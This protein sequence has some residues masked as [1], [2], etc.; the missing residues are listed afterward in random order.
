MRGDY[1]EP[2]KSAIESPTPTLG[3]AGLRRQ[4]ISSDR[5]QSATVKERYSF[6]KEE[7]MMFTSFYSYTEITSWPTSGNSAELSHL[8]LV[9]LCSSLK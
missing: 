9:K 5:A 4:T 7:N 8:G 3:H 6:A 2:A 1:A